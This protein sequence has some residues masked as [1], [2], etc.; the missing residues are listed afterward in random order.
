[1]AQVASILLLAGGCET[2]HSPASPAPTSESLT[3]GYPKARWR[4]LP[5]D[6]RDRVVL[7]PAHI[8]IRHE[9]SRNDGPVAF[10]PFGWTPDG[11]PPRRTNQQALDLAVRVAGWLKRDPHRFAEL[12]SKY[13]D[14]LATRE[15]GGRLGGTRASQLAPVFLDALD[16]LD[17]GKTS[18]VL[19]TDHGFH[20]LLK[21]RPPED[22]RVAGQHLVVRY[23]GTVANLQLGDAT[24]SRE[25][26]L[27]L[28]REL[29]ASKRPFTDLVR[30]HSEDE[31]RL[32]DGDMGV[33]STKAPEFNGALV[34]ALAQLEIGEVSEPIDSPAGI[35][36]LKRVAVV[37]RPTLAVTAIRLAYDDTIQAPAPGSRASVEQIAE[38]QAKQLRADPGAF[39]RT[40]HEGCCTEVLQWTQGT[41]SANLEAAIEKLAVGDVAPHAVEAGGFFLIAKRLEPRASQSPALAYELPRPDKLE[42]EP[43]LR[44]SDGGALA[45]SVQKLR[46]DLQAQ[47]ALV[48]PDRSLLDGA[49]AG[50]QN[51]FSRAQTGD[52]RIAAN[53]RVQAEIATRLS[54]RS[55]E[56]FSG[57]AR[58]WL[59]HEVVENGP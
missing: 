47:L 2:A 34:D 45:A 53:A 50:L 54:P 28:A 21:Q 59:M 20:V 25:Q 10:R 26:A 22:V 3:A 17:W 23:L 40:Q 57:F 44:Y 48:E 16:A 11:P 13:S 52:E 24:R 36:L 38:A 19:K 8:L 56:R 35:Q 33:W 4:V 55:A 12:A 51:A 42:L 46:A 1:M 29:A 31:D 30:E 7:W 43:F 32:R 41:G 5:F 39:E 58:R 15:R 9:A 37:E 18:N 27:A 14:D 49:L 6:A